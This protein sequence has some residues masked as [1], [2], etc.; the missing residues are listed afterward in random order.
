[1]HAVSGQ[2]MQILAELLWRIGNLNIFIIIMKQ[3]WRLKKNPVAYSFMIYE[4]RRTY[5]LLVLQL[6]IMPTL[7]TTPTEAWTP[8]CTPPFP[9]YGWWCSLVL[10]N[11]IRIVGNLWS[12]LFFHLLHHLL[13]R[14]NLLM[15]RP[16]L[17]RTTTPTS[18]PG[19]SETR[20][21]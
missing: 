21:R 1:M 12:V 5:R 7:L 8:F 18:V 9:L 13:V 14:M 20:D 6:A 2:I 3:F 4:F 10:R 19:Q 15:L 11:R 16:N 17:N